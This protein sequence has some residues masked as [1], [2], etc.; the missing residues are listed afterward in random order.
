MNRKNVEKAVVV[1]NYGVMYKASALSLRERV[2]EGRVRAVYQTF[3]RITLTRAS[4]TLSRREMAPDS[5]RTSSLE[6]HFF[7]I[8]SHG[9]RLRLQSAPEAESPSTLV[10]AKR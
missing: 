9:H 2:A 10:T 1:R 3:G 5:S 8:H 6:I 4:H 7:P